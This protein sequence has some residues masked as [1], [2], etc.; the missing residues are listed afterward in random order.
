MDHPC[1]CLFSLSQ[2]EAA[3]SLETHD[4]HSSW[5]IPILKSLPDN[6]LFLLLL[7]LDFG[8]RLRK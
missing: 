2:N 1:Y 3:L 8:D 4:T 6:V 7:S 5:A